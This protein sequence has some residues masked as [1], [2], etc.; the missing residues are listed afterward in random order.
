MNFTKAIV[1]TTNEG[2]EKYSDFTLTFESDNKELLNDLCQLKNLYL[3]AKSSAKCDLVNLIKNYVDSAIISTNCEI[4]NI[5]H[6]HPGQNQLHNRSG[7]SAYHSYLI[8]RG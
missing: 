6:K 4:K 1:S 7:T 2:V 5:K 3:V 8:P